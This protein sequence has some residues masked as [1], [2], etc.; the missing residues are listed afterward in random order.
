MCVWVGGWVGWAGCGCVC[1]PPT[2]QCLWQNPTRAYRLAITR[3]TAVTHGK[4]VYFSV[5][6]YGHPCPGLIILYVEYPTWYSTTTQVKITGSSCLSAK[7]I[8]LGLKLLMGLWQLLEVNLIL[9]A[10][11]LAH[12]HWS[13]VHFVLEEQDGSWNVGPF[14]A[15]HMP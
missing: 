11:V 7:S 6:S 13:L 12:H 10:R 15:F 8:I 1:V 4:E 3:D 2:N 5:S 14:A 9:W